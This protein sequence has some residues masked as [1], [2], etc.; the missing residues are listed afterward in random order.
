M[1]G[2][3]TLLAGAVMHVS[4]GDY[5]IG[6]SGNLT[7]TCCN[8]NCVSVGQNVKRD[9]GGKLKDNIQGNADI[10]IGGALNEKIAGIKKSIA[11][12]QQLIGASVK[13]GSEETNVLTLLTDTLDVVHDLAQICASH[14]HPNTGASGQAA[15]FT[16]TAEK[17]TALKAKYSPLIA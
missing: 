13:L 12:A 3:V 10:T 6:T 5:S 11:A 14:T 7:V 2:T 1:L 15:Q 4:E 16:G 8:D 9:V 17:T